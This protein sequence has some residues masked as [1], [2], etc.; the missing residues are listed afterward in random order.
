MVTPQSVCFWDRS[1]E[2]FVPNSCLRLRV[3]SRQGKYADADDLFQQAVDIE[4][5]KD[6]TGNMSVV[7]TFTNKALVLQLQVSS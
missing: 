1:I 2:W 7:E 4:V 6:G 3:F 5:A